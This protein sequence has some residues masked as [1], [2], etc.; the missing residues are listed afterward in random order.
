MAQLSTRDLVVA[1]KTGEVKL[2]KPADIERVIPDV[3]TST[4]FTNRMHNL[5]P[6]TSVKVD[7]GWNLEA[8]AV[9]KVEFSG[10]LNVERRKTPTR[11]VLDIRAAYEYDQDPGDQIDDEKRVTKDEYRASLIGEYDFK[12]S[13]YIF[14]FPIAER[15]ATRTSWCAPT[16][17][18]AWDTAWPRRASSDSSPGR[19]RLRMG[20]I[21]R[22]P[23]QRVHRAARRLRRRL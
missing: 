6:F 23:Q 11:L 7:F 5:F 22:L 19:H 21:Y 3:E 4:D 18:R 14:G 2:I 15:D 16:L 9:Q 10:G 8:G 13:G 17:P 20:G 12:E 1:E